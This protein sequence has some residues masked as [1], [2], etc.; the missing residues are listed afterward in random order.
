M[1]IK[2]T[3]IEHDL[4][5]KVMDSIPIVGLVVSFECSDIII[6]S[7]SITFSEL[8]SA[9]FIM[10]RARKYVLGNLQNM[11]HKFQNMLITC[12]LEIFRF[13]HDLNII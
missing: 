3:L 6:S 5:D 7:R 8:I 10:T 12:Q 2:F 9:I 13:T 11:P 4:R 1:K